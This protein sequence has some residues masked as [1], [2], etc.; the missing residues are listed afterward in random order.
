MAVD[1]HLNFMSRGIKE[2]DDSA[3]FSSAEFSGMCRPAQVSI[4]NPFTIDSAL[5]GG[6]KKRMLSTPMRMDETVRT[7]FGPDYTSFLGA[8]RADKPRNLYR[9]PFVLH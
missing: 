5:E 8:A 6:K 7:Q 1:R 2:S 9:N 3:G 4:T